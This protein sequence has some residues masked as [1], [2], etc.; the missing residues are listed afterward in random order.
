[1]ILF[2]FEEGER[3][4]ID[5]LDFWHR[6]RFELDTLGTDGGGEKQTNL[7]PYYK[8]NRAHT[9]KTVFRATS[10]EVVNTTACSVLWESVIHNYTL[11]RKRKRGS[12]GKTDEH[13]EI[14]TLNLFSLSDW[15]HRRLICF[16]VLAFLLCGEGG[17]QEAVYTW[18]LLVWLRAG[19]SNVYVALILLYRL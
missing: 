5:Q 11:C 15:L 7:H 8:D 4:R 13:V 19:V 2:L 18:G 1:M 16:G 14:S 9:L 3:G 10:A 17:E 12:S 6:H